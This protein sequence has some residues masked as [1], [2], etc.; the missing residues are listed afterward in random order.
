MKRITRIGGHFELSLVL[1]PFIRVIGVIRGSKDVIPTIKIT[2]LAPALIVRH[3]E[4]TMSQQNCTA[5]LAA[6]I[7]TVAFPAPGRG[8]DWE[9][10]AEVRQKVVGD[11]GCLSR[12]TSRT[13]R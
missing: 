2:Q 12:L 13:R 6:M 11:A 10:A 7:F 1:V 5:L 8:G 3:A 9:P 4:Q